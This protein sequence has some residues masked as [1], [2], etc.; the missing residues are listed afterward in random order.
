MHGPAE[1]VIYT[2]GSAS[3]G[4][5]DGGAAAVI[6]M[7]PADH[8][9]VV[10]TLRHRGRT[11]TSSY[12][13]EKNAMLLALEWIAQNSPQGATVICSDSQSLLKAISNASDDSVLIRRKL[14]GSSGR[15]VLQWIPGHVDIPG[16]EA[17]DVAAKESAA[18]T[19]VLAICT[20]FYQ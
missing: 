15:E 18:M 12:E 6:T 16:N 8:P 11:I 4:T 1:F 3:E 5:H 7:G 20:Q 9:T 19:D 17:A 10:D 2:D 14:S 13:E